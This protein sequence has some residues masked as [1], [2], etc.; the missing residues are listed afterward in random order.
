MIS[1]RWQKVIATL[2]FTAIIFFLLT[3]AIP[4]IP[5]FTNDAI[6]ILMV[7]T[8]CITSLCL[9]IPIYIGLTIKITKFLR[10]RNEERVS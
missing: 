8:G 6:S 2:I 9:L 4:F 7:I 10:K 3:L 1:E 5:I